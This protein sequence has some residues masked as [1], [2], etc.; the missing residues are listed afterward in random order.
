MAQPIIPVEAFSSL[1]GTGGS[2]AGA[3]MD[4]HYRRMLAITTIEDSWVSNGPEGPVINQVQRLDISEVAGPG[5][6]HRRLYTAPASA[7]KPPFGIVSILGYTES[8][9]A[10]YV[11]KHHGYLSALHPDIPVS[12]EATYGI[13]DTADELTAWQKVRLTHDQVAER[14][15]AVMRYLYPNLP[16]IA[17]PTSQAASIHARIRKLN[18]AD[19]EPIEFQDQL[20]YEPYLLTKEQKCF[21]ILARFVAGHVVIDGTRELLTNTN[22]SEILGLWLDQATSAHAMRRDLPALVGHGI[23]NLRRT[24]HSVIAGMLAK[25]ALVIQGSRDCLGCEATNSLPG[26]ELKVVEGKGHSMGMNPVKRAHAISKALKNR[27]HI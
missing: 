21:G 9:D 22:P 12:T 17:V 8:I 25:G 19:G 2:E 24:E 27:G 7:L 10:E 18:E 16:V 1:P 5:T 23:S 15:Y 14:T 6:V 26:V 4:D 11:R 13:D 3:N 20:L